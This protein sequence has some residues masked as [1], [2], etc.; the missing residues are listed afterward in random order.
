[1]ATNS[2]LER[3]TR[4]EQAPMVCQLC[5]IEPK[6]KFKCLDCEM[7]M[8]QRCCDKVHPKFPSAKPI[9]L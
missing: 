4:T 3:S 1:M 6:V 5:E 8:C 7:M 9:Q 2:S